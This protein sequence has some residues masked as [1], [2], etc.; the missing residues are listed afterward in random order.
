MTTN[1]DIRGR[2]LAQLS[3]WNGELPDDGWFHESRHLGGVID[4]L[5]RA[6]DSIE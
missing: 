1:V 5:A 4:D 6:G 3:P 2:D